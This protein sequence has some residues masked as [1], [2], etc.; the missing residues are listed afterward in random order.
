MNILLTGASGF[1]GQNLT[2]ELQSDGHQVKSCSRKN[3]FDFNRMISKEAWIPHLKNIDVVINCVGIIYETKKQTFK[4]LHYQAPEALFN[5][6]SES[7]LKRVI[8]ISALG[9]DENSVA[10]YHI[11]KK[12][13][14]DVLRALPLN[15][16]VL[17][18]SLVY[19]QGGKSTAFFRRLARFPVLPLME[20][21]SQMVQPVHINDLTDTVINCLS[22]DKT[23]ITI[24]VVGAHAISFKNWLQLMRTEENK[25]EAYI[26]SISFKLSLAISRFAKY[27][28]PLMQTENIRMLQKGNYGD[29]KPLAE[30][31][32]H[33][34]LDIKT[35]WSKL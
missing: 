13:A 18:P 23:N 35:G 5:A 2:K 17:R 12:S 11:T 7:N 26:F 25:P 4:V 28:I 8:Q 34:P 14:D 9:A 33:M 24:D 10:P 3:G 29:V 27:F 20:G 22:T 6:C 19:G 30:F 21:G 15:W 16:F 32:G 1:I 31:L